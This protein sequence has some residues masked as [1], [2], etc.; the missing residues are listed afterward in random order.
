MKQK[1]TTNTIQRMICLFLLVPLILG[2]SISGMRASTQALYRAWNL[3]VYRM[4][5]MVWEYE[6]LENQEEREEK[7]KLEYYVSE[8]QNIN[9]TYG[10]EDKDDFALLPQ[11]DRNTE[12]VQMIRQMAKDRVL[13]GMP[14]TELNHVICLDDESMDA[15]LPRADEYQVWYAE[16]DIGRTRV[17]PISD[18][19]NVTM[20][21]TGYIINKNMKKGYPLKENLEPSGDHISIGNENLYLM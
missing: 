12:D 1:Y 18:T 15:S 14:E 4:E 13:L 3:N 9:H 5:D 21:H 7:D 19:E 17:V 8:V 6:V 20:L 16:A 10:L 11:R 2:I